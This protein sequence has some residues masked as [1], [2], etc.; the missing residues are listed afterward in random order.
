ME[1]PLLLPQKPPM[2]MVDSLVEYTD[3]GAVTRLGVRPDNVFVQ[4]GQLAE[5]GLVENIAQ[6]AAAHAGHNNVLKGIAEAPLG[7]IAAVDHLQIHKLPAVHSTIETSI[8]VIQ[9]VLNVTIIAGTV[10]CEGE[11]IAQCE[12][13]IFIRT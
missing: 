11:P 4:N 3:L 1:L 13:K 9:Q 10:V 7:Y 12:M 6:T 5:P 8:R 2:V